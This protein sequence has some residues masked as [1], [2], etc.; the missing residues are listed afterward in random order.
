MLQINLNKT[1]I[2]IIITHVDK[3]D[4]ISKYASNCVA[5]IHNYYAMQ[6]YTTIRPSKKWHLCAVCLIR[7]KSVG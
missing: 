4:K 5:Y 7:R 3:V 2:M 6:L 1:H